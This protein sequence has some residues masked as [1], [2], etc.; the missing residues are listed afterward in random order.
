MPI[1]RI[2]NACGKRGIEI[3]KV[4]TVSSSLQFRR[5]FSLGP[6]HICALSRGPGLNAC[7][8]HPPAP[9]CQ[10]RVDR[11]HALPPDRERAVQWQLTPRPPSHPSPLLPPPPQALRTTL[12]LRQALAAPATFAAGDAG[13]LNDQTGVLATTKRVAEMA[14]TIAQS[15]DAMQQLDASGIGD[16]RTSLRTPVAMDLAATE[17]PFERRAAMPIGDRGANNTAIPM[18]IG[19]SGNLFPGIAARVVTE[20]PQGGDAARA[21]DGAVAR[22]AAADGDSD[23]ARAADDD[24]DEVLAG[25]LGADGDGRAAAGGSTRA[26]TARSRTTMP[27]DERKR[28]RAAAEQARRVRSRQLIGAA[29]AAAAQD[30]PLTDEQR[31]VLDGRDRERA[32][33]RAKRRRTATENDDRDDR[34]ELAVAAAVIAHLAD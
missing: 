29:E 34:E 5:L 24:S 26:P 21:A 25:G 10:G 17:L 7:V 20:P 12:Q 32:R 6:I 28:R 9:E 19:L 16:L 1:A 11:S 15:E 4:W 31:R 13:A 23:T 22:A 30:G 27:A 8:T 33:R 3:L 14:T 2:G 18:P